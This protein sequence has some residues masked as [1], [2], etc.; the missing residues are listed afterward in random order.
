LPFCELA[1]GLEGIVS[2]DGML[3]VKSTRESES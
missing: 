3:D 2:A 1:E